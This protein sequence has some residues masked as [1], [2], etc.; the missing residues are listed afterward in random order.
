MQPIKITSGSPTRT[1]KRNQFIQFRQTSA[2]VIPV[3]LSWLHFNYEWWVQEISHTI[4]VT[5]T[6]FFSL[7][8]ISKQQLEAPPRTKLFHGR[9]H[10]RYIG[11]KSNHKRKKL[12]RKNQGSS[13]L[14]DNFSNIDNTPNQFRRETEF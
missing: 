12:H 7:S 5:H 11:I 3:S 14:W 8:S 10:G 2:K 6:R 9:P 1:R 13:F 4:I